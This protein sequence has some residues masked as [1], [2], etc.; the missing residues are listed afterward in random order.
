MLMAAT[1][2]ASVGYAIPPQQSRGV[3]LRRLPEH[4]YNARILTIVQTMRLECL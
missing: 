1:L 3:F 4:T 2:Q